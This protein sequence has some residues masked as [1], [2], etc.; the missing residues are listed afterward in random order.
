MSRVQK[1]Q[2]KLDI[3]LMRALIVILIISLTIP[4]YTGSLAVN[5]E[6][7]GNYK[8]PDQAQMIGYVFPNKIQNTA[9]ISEDMNRNGI[10]DFIEYNTDLYLSSEYL[11]SIITLT[12]P[13]N[14]AIVTQLSALGCIIDHKFNIVN[15]IGASV[16][17][18]RLKLIGRLPGVEMVQSVR[19]VEHN[20]NSAVPLTK[21]SQDKLSAGGYSG[22]TGEGV[23]IAVIDSGVDGTHST[24]GNRIIAFRDFVYGNNDLDPTDGMN[25]RD[26]GYH[27][28]MCASCAAGSGTYKGVAIKANIIAITSE[29]TYHMIQ[30]IEWCINNK[31]KDFNK[32]GIPDGPDIITMSLGMDGIYQIL[33]NAA[34][35]AMDNGVVF[36]TSAGN[37]GPQERTVYSPASSEKVIA[38]GATDK[39][40]KVI[41]S[42]S[43]RGPGP[44]GIIKPNVVA[45]GEN[46]ICAYPGN[47]WTGYGTGT[48]FSG[49]I[50][51]GICALLLQ[52]DP[53]L[54]TYEVKKI[55]QDSALDRGE[56][57][58]DNTYGWGFV[59]AV[60]ALNQVLKVK[61]IVPSA[62]TVIEDT[63]VSFTAMVSVPNINKY[64]WDWENDGIYD[65]ETVDNSASHVFTDADDYTL[66]V[67]VTNSIGK[68]ATNTVDITVINREPDA[69]IGI[70][71]IPEYIY[72]DQVLIFNA[73]R[74]WDTP[75]DIINLE[76]SWS[77]NNGDNFTNFSKKDKIIEHAFT[78]SGGYTIVVKVRDDDGEFDVDQMSINV[79]NFKPIADAGDDRTVYEDELVTFSA[80][81]TYDTRSDL[82]T[83]NYTWNFGDSKKDFGMNTTHSYKLEEN[84]ETFSVTLTVSDDN[85]EKSQAKIKVT[86]INRPPVINL[87]DDITAFE[88]EIIYLNGFGNDSRNDKELLVYR[89]DYNDGSETDWLEEPKTSHIYT[90]T[91]TYHPK[92][93]VKDP[94]GAV[95]SKSMNIT[96]TNVVPKASFMISKNTVE[97][98]ELVEFDAGFSTD[99]QSDL[100]DLTFIWDFGDGSNGLGKTIS[101]K[102]YY[103]KR[104]TIT[105]KVIDDDG[106]TSMFE[107][108]IMVLNRIPT[109]KI[110]MKET[111]YMIDEIVRFYGFQ[112]SDT[113]SDLKNLTY[114]WDFRDGKGFQIAGMNTTY[115]YTIPGEYVVR[116]KVEDDNREIDMKKVTIT[117]NEPKKEVDIFAN[118]TFENRGM[119]I[120]TAII[121]FIV[122]LIILL[123]SSLMYYNNK[124][125]LFGAIDRKLTERRKMKEMEKQYDESRANM[126]GESGLTIGQENFYQDLYGIH[127][128]KF[129]DQPQN[130]NF[131]YQKPNMDSTDPGLGLGPVQSQG[132]GMGPGVSPGVGP[133]MGPGF[134]APIKQNTLPISNSPSS[135]SGQVMLPPPIEQNQN[136]LLPQ[137]PPIPNNQGANNLNNNK[138]NEDKGKNKIID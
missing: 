67:K 117:I 130:M 71:D 47:Q 120:Y 48:S 61:S 45:P 82:E 60:A 66:G 13:A 63:E 100:E 136:Q 115:K 52:Y 62:S 119:Y 56:E 131:N 128:S 36:V 74:S 51:A 10:E 69:K 5:I 98:D 16:P 7:N 112:S 15:A 93:Y 90:E 54:D 135:P 28:T 106:A 72:E 125:G 88:D 65:M 42:F 121:I 27:G 122:I 39:Y 17:I 57:G 20:L 77:F 44:G 2:R 33:D 85:F 55:L 110:T 137:L 102:F 73:S 64:E 108:N 43:S 49:P 4:I 32:D 105:L 126:I 109:A 101:H 111:E 50:V 96:I 40:N 38:V 46:I 24:F 127:P 11:S 19:E 83:L 92:L 138:N 118:P 104:Y 18:N 59:D 79:D 23:T 14:E 75:S 35:A 78:S 95:N 22:I 116:L 58:P 84:N 123:L 26:Y 114:Y 134:D 29:N 81:E 34:G 87:I 31:N 1:V 94:K 30:A 89:W 124:K 41:T 53:E 132:V 8:H 86:V 9:G 12:E 99:S 68:S 97:E 6:Q 76:Y 70:D 113:P 80:Y 37:D 103:A 3:F 129:K 133:G 25:S 107:D 91:G 21:A